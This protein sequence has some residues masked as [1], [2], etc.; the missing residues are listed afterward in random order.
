ME[1]NA[2]AGRCH[3]VEGGLKKLE[4]VHIDKDDPVFYLY[5]FICYILS[6]S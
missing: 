6:K 3:R 1:E 2:I 4:Y 5:Y